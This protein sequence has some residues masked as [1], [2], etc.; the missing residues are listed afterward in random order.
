MRY[1]LINE[2]TLLTPRVSGLTGGGTKAIPALAYER[3]SNLSIHQLTILFFFL[4]LPF[5]EASCGYIIVLGF[6]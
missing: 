4:E 6:W 2:G 1:S 5:F 3:T